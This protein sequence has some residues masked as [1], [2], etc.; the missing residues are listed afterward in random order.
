M[1]DTS[2]ASLPRRRFLAGTALA[3]GAVAAWSRR[4][5]ADGDDA[6]L[7]EIEER[8][9]IRPPGARDE[10][11]FRA[12]C[13]SCGV[14]GSVCRGEK[15]DAITIASGFD[16]GGLEAFGTPALRNMRDYPCTLC[17]EC[18][19]RCPSGALQAMEKEQ[20]RMGMALIDFRVCFGWNGDV[21]LSC[22]KACPMGA[23]VF[24]FYNGAWGNQPYI[25]EKCV[26]CGL[27]VKYCP[28]GGSA[29]KVVT[30]ATYRKVLVGYQ[31]RFQ[32]LLNMPADERYRVVYEE[33]MPR[34]LARGRLV[35]REYR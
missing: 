18:P 34:I 9:L 16:G 8:G 24:D 7:A 29:I 30:R 23:K 31:E 1:S 3:V 14:C 26:G 19:G 28:M 35:E 21:C 22:S 27:C 13:V 33:N 15:F 10:R 2:P 32:Q 4:A 6:P 5:C 25:N 11:E 20:V 12:R 17:M